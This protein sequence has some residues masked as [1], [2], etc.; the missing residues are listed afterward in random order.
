M[1][2]PGAFG[3]C[4]HF[5]AGAGGGPDRQ[6]CRCGG[7]RRRADDA[8]YTVAGALRSLRDET[9][10]LDQRTVVVVDEA[11]MVGT[12]ELCATCWLRPPRPV[13]KPC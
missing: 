13:S 4:E 9:L 7:A 10:P 6:S 8:G 3:T 1:Q 11:G 2:Y 12:E 5:Q